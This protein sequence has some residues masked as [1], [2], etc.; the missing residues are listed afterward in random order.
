MQKLWSTPR[1]LVTAVTLCYNQRDFLERAVSSV[2]EHNGIDSEDIEYYIW[3]NGPPYDD[4]RQYLDNLELPGWATK[5]GGGF[6]V[7]VGAAVNRVIE[8]TDS[9]FIFKFDDDCAL[10]PLT[11]PLL[12]IAHAFAGS[13]GLPLAV[14]SADVL[15]VGKAQGSHVDYELMP[16]LVLE[17]HSCVGGGAVLIPRKVIED[18]GPFREDRLYGVEDGD[19]AVRCLKKGYINCYLRDAYH[20]SFCRGQGADTRFDSWKLEYTFGDTD[21][22]FDKWMK[23]RTF[24]HGNLLK[25]EK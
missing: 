18:V 16:G 25:G 19:F 23:A 15:G 5:T 6:N 10:L 8:Q 11:L 1:K 14:L 13:Y 24:D 7:G 21:L 22:G 4:S 9:E 17:S 20:V 3:D 2:I 12:L